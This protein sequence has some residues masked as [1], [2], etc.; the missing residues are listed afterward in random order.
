[1]Y[2]SIEELMNSRCA[3]D[4]LFIHHGWSY[5]AETLY[6]RP[7]AANTPDPR[8]VARM[9]VKRYRINCFI[10]VREA[11]AAGDRDSPGA[12]RGM[13][14]LVIARRLT[15]KF[16]EAQFAVL[17]EPEAERVRELYTDGFIRAIW[18]RNDV[19]G[20]CFMLECGDLDEAESI[21]KTLPLNA[22][23]MLETQI[24]PL[25]GYRGFAPLGTS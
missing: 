13:Q 20:A 16:S 18:S 6:G 19:L 7:W 10:P 1:M 17:L 15:E 14:F 3:A 12:P 25:R 22:A 4:V 5:L 9:A 21:V 23:A 8:P 2:A 11:A 24:I